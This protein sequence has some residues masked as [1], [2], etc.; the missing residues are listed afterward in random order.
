MAL[1]IS[2][3]AEAALRSRAKFLDVDPDDYA[4]QALLE[5][6]Q[7]E[8]EDNARLQREFESSGLAATLDEQM[9]DRTNYTRDRPL[10]TK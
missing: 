3:E 9:K 4:S 2:A 8:N 1:N 10:R 6:V 7:A 5:W